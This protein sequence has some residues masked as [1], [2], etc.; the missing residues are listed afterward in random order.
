MITTEKKSKKSVLLF[1]LIKSL[2]F[3][4][5]LEIIANLIILC[6]FQHIH[7]DIEEIS[8]ENAFG[9]YLKDRDK[10]GE[11]IVNALLY[12]GFTMLDW[13]TKEQK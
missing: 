2:D 13:I 12:T 1:N 11:T 10:N 4:D 6:S 5:K 8:P 9:A 3:K 7:T